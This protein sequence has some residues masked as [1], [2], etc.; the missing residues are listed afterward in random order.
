MAL[1][2]QQSEK[3]IGTPE[4]LKE[5]GLNPLMFSSC[6]AKGTPGHKECPWYSKN[7]KFPG[8]RFLK[9]LGD[10]KAPVTVG[11]SIISGDNNTG[12]YVEMQCSDYYTSGLY[13]RNQHRAITGDT[14]KVVSIEGDGVK[15]KFRESFALHPTKDPNCPDC[16]KLNC[17]K[18]V[19]RLVEREVEPF[20]RPRE[21]FAST[22]LAQEMRD[23]QEHETDIDTDVLSLRVPGKEEG[24][25]GKR[26][27]S[28]V[29]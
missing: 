26:R 19:E 2:I 27:G 28:S 14:I 11:I 12:N 3:P 10:R 20:V 22:A 16:A 8:C 29:A 23:A 17:K 21:R 24:A 7:E 18:R 9:V 15:L 6:C 13:K 25:S 4:E 1:E 5:I